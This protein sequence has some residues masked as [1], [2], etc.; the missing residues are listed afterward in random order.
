MPIGSVY[1]IQ[2]PVYSVASSVPSVSGAGATAA[3]IAAAAG[4]TVGGLADTVIFRKVVWTYP[5]RGA[6]VPTYP[7]SVALTGSV[8]R[9][10][11][12]T[13]VPEGANAE[14]R[15]KSQTILEITTAEDPCTSLGEPAGSS[16]THWRVEWAGFKL[17]VVG[18]A[19]PQGSG[20]LTEAVLTL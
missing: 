15:L 19:I 5:T 16:M 2:P 3:A 12:P 13:P 4:G 9:K 14:L 10:G 11:R 8:V 20:W 7:I 1:I 6:S 17:L 18:A